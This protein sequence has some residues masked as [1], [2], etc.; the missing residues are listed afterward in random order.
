MA[1]CP[2]S[3]DRIVSVNDQGKVLYRAEKAAV[4]RYPLFGDA[5]FS[6]G[7]CRNFEVFDPL[8][9]IAEL[10]QHIPDGGM[11]LVR[12][13]GWYSNKVR[14]QRAKKAQAEMIR[15]GFAIDESLSGEEEEDESMRQGLK[16]ARMRWAAL[17]K[18]VYE[19]DPLECQKCGAQMK[20]ISFIERK[21]QPQVV[22]K[23]LKHC[24]LWNQTPSR[25]PP[26]KVEHEQL[27]LELEFVPIDQFLASF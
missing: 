14:G 7:V 11:Q 27:G 10:T 21:D 5:R 3:L 2:F 8:D 12:Y 6:P 19:V 1:R 15:E 9:F 26:I 23:I 17:I 4:H 24:G 16:A 13:M 18:R 20:I 22:E 25:A